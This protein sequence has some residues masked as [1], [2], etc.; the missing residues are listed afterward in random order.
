MQVNTIS[1]P[2]KGRSFSANKKHP[3][4]PSNFWGEYQM[5]NVF[6]VR[7]ELALG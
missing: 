7:F 5:M 3:K 1:H 4:S 6:W 2:S